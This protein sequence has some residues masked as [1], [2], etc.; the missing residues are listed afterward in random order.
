M[1]LF[2]KSHDPF[3]D[4]IDGL[5]QA[6]Q[7]ESLQEE[8]AS[9]KN[10]SKQVSMKKLA[11]IQDFA[12]RRAKAGIRHY[13]AADTGRWESDW[14][15]SG[16]TPY[17][18]TKST[19]DRMINRSRRL[20]DNC[21]WADAVPQTI[22]SNVVCDGIRPIPTVR[23][24]NGDPDETI[25]KELAR[26]WDR[27]NDE[28]D[29]TGHGTFYENQ[30]L[31]LRTIIVSGSVLTIEVPSRSG[32]MLPIAFQMREP[33]RLDSGRDVTSKSVYNIVLQPQIVHGIAIDDA[34]F[35]VGYFWR[36]ITD[37]MDSKLVNHVFI[38]RR[39]EQS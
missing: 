24:N 11:D 15:S 32:S 2:T 19:L 18:N 9:L 29:R 8:N 20:V 17:Q 4:V 10:D 5:R 23:K 33:D 27:F 35:P 12:V 37:M 3:N 25:N 39:P 14:Q 6:K 31:A 1:G 26:L 7:I 36:G 28:W 30:R 21:G 34:D 22:V 13:E 38:K 16:D